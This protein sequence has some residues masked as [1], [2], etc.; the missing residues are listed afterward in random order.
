MPYATLRFS[1]P[2]E[3]AE[4]MLAVHSVET[5]SRIEDLD[6]DL[7][8]FTKYDGGIFK[9]MTKEDVIEAIRARLG[10]MRV[11]DA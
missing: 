9:N 11:Q 7:R 1:L 6:E 2:E 4:H 8:Q 3:N 5:M 10:E